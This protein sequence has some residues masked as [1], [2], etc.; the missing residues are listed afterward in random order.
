MM[1]RVPLLV[2]LAFAGWSNVASAE[3]AGVESCY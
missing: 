3:Q 1:T 2:V